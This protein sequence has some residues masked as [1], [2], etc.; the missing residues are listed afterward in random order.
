MKGKGFKLIDDLKSNWLRSIGSAVIGAIAGALIT[1]SLTS[2]TTNHKHQNTSSITVNPAFNIIFPDPKKNEI[3]KQIP[4]TNA[5]MATDLHFSEKFATAYQADLGQEWKPHYFIQKGDLMS[6]TAFLE[7]F[8]VKVEGAGPPG[9]KDVQQILNCL[10][11]I[12]VPREIQIKLTPSL[13]LYIVFRNIVNLPLKKSF[14]RVFIHDLA[15]MRQTNYEKWI[16]EVYAHIE[17]LNELLENPNIWFKLHPHSN[18]REE[19]AL[20]PKNI[21]Q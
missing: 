18:E 1:V 5:A 12:A 13:S 9:Y 4:Q 6:F 10:K 11:I 7:Y 2:R 19:C 21:F 16:N 8:V 17:T 15:T 20:I 14:S 3:M